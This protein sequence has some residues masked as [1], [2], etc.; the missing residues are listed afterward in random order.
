MPEL[1]PFRIFMG[2]LFEI[3]KAK[4]SIKV[5]TILGHYSSTIE[6]PPHDNYL[7]DPQC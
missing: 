6:K 5:L 1:I 2:T 7:E 4:M 3:K